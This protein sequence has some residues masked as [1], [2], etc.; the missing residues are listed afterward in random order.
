MVATF[1]HVEKVR[2]LHFGAN[3]LQKIQG[4]KRIERALHKEDRCRQ[5]AQDFIAKFCPIAHR[6]E[7]VSETNKTVHFF[8]ERHMTSNAPTHAFA[9]QNSRGGCRSSG[10]TPSHR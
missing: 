8:F 5:G 6:A 4:T 10:S 3:A 2:D 1:D 9:D 7:R